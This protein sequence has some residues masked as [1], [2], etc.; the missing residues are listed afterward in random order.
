M[1]SLAV[2]AVACTAVLLPVL[3]AAAPITFDQALERAVQRSE[4]ARSA[5]AGTLSAAE[6]AKSAGQL[7]DP[8]LGVSLENLPVTGADR[9]STTRESMTMKRLSLGQEWVSPEKRQLRTDAAQAVT[10]REA[11]NLAAMLAETRLQTAVAYIDTYYAG[12]AFKLAAQAESHAREATATGRAKLSTATASAADVLALAAAQGSSA[13]EALE[14]RQQL[15][16]SAV[17]LT[18]WTGS[19]ETELLPPPALA[20]LA[21]QAWVE[22]HPQVVAKRRDVIVAQKDAASVAANRRPNWSWE[23]SYGQRT[24]YSDL[25]SVG[26]RIPLPIAPASRQDRDTASK[27]ALVE[28]AEA[29]LAET[30]RA[31]EAEYQ[32]L[33][34]DAQRLEERIKFYESSVLAPAMQRTAAARAAFASNQTGAAGLFDARHAELEARRKLLTLNRD[35]AKVRAQLAFKPVKAEDLQ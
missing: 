31:A 18:R 15:A 23:V 11:A 25:A 3:A 21:Q 7:P 10:A 8:M 13:D 28:K 30:S 20:A 29:D 22:A 5:R 2:R 16:A 4:A 33:G 26:V 6:A 27:L 9:F 34:S 1:F 19:S 24:G 14:A 35:L 12:E 32:S 17:S